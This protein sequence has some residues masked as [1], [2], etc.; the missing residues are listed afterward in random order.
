MPQAA[1]RLYIGIDPS[2]SNTGVVCLNE[3]GSLVLALDGKNAPGASSRNKDDIGRY[4][5]QA[6]YILEA[7]EALEGEISA[8]AYEDYSFDSVHRAYSLAEYGGILKLSLKS[9]DIESML[10]IAP[11]QNK[12]FATGS[13]F[14][15]KGYVREAAFRECPE[16]ER[17]R[18]SSDICDAYFLAKIAWYHADSDAAFHCERDRQYCKNNLRGRFELLR[19][20]LRNPRNA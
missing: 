12:K 9:L 13:G 7:L 10:L 4:Q 17:S 15:G 3:S 18:A 5:A 6:S 1:K 20:I 14:S 2:I 11:T 16:L 19:K 8:I